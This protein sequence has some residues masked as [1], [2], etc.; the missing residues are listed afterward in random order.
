MR[1]FM[2]ERAVNLRVAVINQPG[3]QRDQSALKIGASSR[4]A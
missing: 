4:A 2:S 1:E 3:I